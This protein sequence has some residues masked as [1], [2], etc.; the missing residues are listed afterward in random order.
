MIQQV[1]VRTDDL[2]GSVSHKPTRTVIETVPFEIDGGSYEIDLTDRH[3][4]ELRKMLAPWIEHARRPK[5][6]P[7]VT[8]N[9]SRPGGSRRVRQRDT[10]AIRAWAKEHGWPGIKPRGRIPAEAEDAYHRAHAA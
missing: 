8:A 7:P 4:A 6:A 3:A 10:N 5:A 9:G 1:E 2:D